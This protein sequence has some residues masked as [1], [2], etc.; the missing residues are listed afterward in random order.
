V[1]THGRLAQDVDVAEAALCGYL[2]IKGLT[3]DYPLLTTYF[4]AE[5]IGHKHTFVTD[6]WEADENVDWQHW[7]CT[8]STKPL[9]NDFSTM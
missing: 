6:K 8:P 7:V 3:A 1:C 4:E 2:E 5:I 9:H